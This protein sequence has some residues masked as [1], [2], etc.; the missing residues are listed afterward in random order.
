MV[1][2]SA[3]AA[4]N[5][6]MSKHSRTLAAHKLRMKDELSI[7]MQLKDPSKLLEEDELRQ[8]WEVLEDCKDIIETYA[9]LKPFRIFGF[10]VEAS[11]VFTIF[12][13]G[14]SFVGVLFSIYSTSSSSEEA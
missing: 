13:T 1:I 11:S 3:G 4:V 8:C 2:A 7:L 5:M 14:L 6:E 12:S 10:K 9:E